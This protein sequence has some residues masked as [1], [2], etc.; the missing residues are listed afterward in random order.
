MKFGVF[1]GRFQPVHNGHLSV[2]SDALSKVDKL[3]IVIGSA[4]TARNVK[5]PW[6][7]GERQEMIQACLGQQCLDVDTGRYQF[8]WINDYTYNDNMWVSQVQNKVDEATNGSDDITLFGP[9]KD[10]TS[11]Y[12]SLFPQW[13]TSSTPLVSGIDATTIRNM[14]FHCDLLGLQKYVPD[15]VL[16][17]LKSCMMYNAVTPTE[18]FI[19][20]KDE[21]EQVAAYK[22]AWKGA[23]FPPTFV[24]T[25]AVVIKS[26]HILVVRRKCQPGKGL[27]AL[28]GGFLGQ[29]ER[30]V[31]GCIRE[32]KEETRIAVDH[33]T[34]EKS[35][36]SQR[37]FDHPDRSL[38]GRTITHAFAFDLGSGKLPKVKGS[39]DAEK[40]LWVPIS[41]VSGRG[42]EFYEDHVHIVTW[43]VNRF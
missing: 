1:I 24:T 19:A 10:R 15:C 3:L 4:N 12:L 22:E 42:S 29:H 34:L 38:R 21:F 41:E 13:K 20:L 39:D 6:T 17:R 11:F 27:L 5:N 14:Y 7:P 30:I 28:P 2:I 33:E 18:S 32:L 31:D 36:V 26:G 43:F 23:P 16:Q 9:N 8:I 25:D 35:I 37:V 40:A